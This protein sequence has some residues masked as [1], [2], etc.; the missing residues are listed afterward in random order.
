MASLTIKDLDERTQRL[1]QIRAAR[2]NRSMEEEARSILKAA[3]AE[4]DGD[5]PDLAASIKARFRS[6]GVEEIELPSR[7]PLREP[8]VL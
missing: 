4:D 6:L 5:K 7:A 2:Q 8:P 1:L 3:V